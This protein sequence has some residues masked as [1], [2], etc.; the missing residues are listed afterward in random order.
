MGERLTKA[1]RWLSDLFFLPFRLLQRLLEGMNLASAAA[2]RGLW[3]LL[4]R[5]GLALRRMLVAV[6]WQVA[7]AAV[8]R[9]WRFLGQMGL[10][11]RRLI[12]WTFWEQP[13]FLAIPLRWL[14]RRTLY[15]PV[16]FTWLSLR[17]FGA[18]LF[19]PLLKVLVARWQA[20]APWRMRRRLR[21]RS[22]LIL[23]RARLAVAVRRPAPPRTTMVAPRMRVLARPAPRVSRFT[24]AVVTT[25]LVLLLGVITTQ[26]RQPHRAAAGAAV[27]RVVTPTPG[28]ARPGAA[29]V[30]AG[31]AASI[32]IQLTPWPT[33]DLLSQGGSLAFTARSNGN[34]DI[35]VLVVGQ[36]DPVR[37]T[38]HLADDRDPAWSPDGRY[39]AFASHRD[40][41]WE[42]Y[43]LELQTGSLRRLTEDLAF[44]GGPS[45]SPDGQW[46]VYESYKENNLD[47]Y[48]I[49]ADGGSPPI[50]LTEHPAQ[51]F[52][53]AWS[54]G[55]R[56]IVFTSWRGGNRDI[57][58]MPLN[59]ASDER[60]INITQSPA[61]FE[62]HAAFDPGGRYLAYY[63][64]GAGFELVYAIP[65][66]D[67]EP[68]GPPVSVGQGRH[69][70]WAPDGS[71]VLYVHSNENR[72]YLLASSVDAWSVAPQA[73]ASDDT[74]DDLAWSAV[75]LPRDLV[76]QLPEVAQSQDEPLYVEYLKPPEGNGPPYQLWEVE[77]NAPSPYLSDRVNDSFAAL[78]QRVLDEVGWDFLG[79]ADN[80]FAPLS[81]LPFP[82]QPS[83]TWNKA[84]RAFDFYY[85][86]ALADD[87]QMEIVR[88]ERGYET[89]WRVFLKAAVQDGTQGEPM[90]DLPWD[91]RARYGFDPQYYD[92]GGK[93][94]DV[95]PAGYY[96]DFT[97]L[98][99]DYGWTRVPAVPSWHTYFQGI[100]YWHFENRQGL[101]WEEAMLE[102]YTAE[103]LE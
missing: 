60:A 75:A 2:G 72:N 40:G 82:G 92:Q 61:G 63:D 15:R 77:A 66:E 94:K 73:Y 93:W 99:A 58:L 13:L 97:A 10:A 8:R 56:H 21:W 50:R 51:D 3:G 49:R 35:Y 23:W 74:L 38:A 32:G 34:S 69:P 71:S 81:A 52:S 102:L 46:L 91:F 26:T 83:Q 4:G 103:E 9:L 55:G 30:S 89:Y 44:D 54:P 64:D 53:P 59:S 45:W 57:Y 98:A 86:H 25:S 16:R 42:L 20:T 22:R 41:N 76:V 70:S 43:V 12:H 47:L 36:P 96:L 7:V 6:T 65:L 101:S 29:L 88:E 67:Y 19:A 27:T 31:P 87:P 37:L 28:P 11:L 62:D 80:L 84:G 5:M 90:R 17:A 78:R 33:P 39:L 48:I 18:W 100:L 24:T 79:Q 68:A 14:Y 1:G 95:V 85:R